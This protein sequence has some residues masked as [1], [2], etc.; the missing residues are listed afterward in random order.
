MALL[1]FKDGKESTYIKRKEKGSLE[2]CKHSEEKDKSNDTQKDVKDAR[3]LTVTKDL[4]QLDVSQQKQDETCYE[5]NKKSLRSGSQQ[6]RH[7][8]GKKQHKH[9]QN[10]YANQSERKD[11]ETV[12]Q[13]SNRHHHLQNDHENNENSDP[14][15]TDQT[16]KVSCIQGMI[17]IMKNFYF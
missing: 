17:H 15:V 5:E 4:E 13:P 6:R 1:H 3:A 8:Q 14:N 2:E 16:K 12:Q 9:D 10:T 11:D 7:K